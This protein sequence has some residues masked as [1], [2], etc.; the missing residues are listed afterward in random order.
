MQK[1]VEQLE[2]GYSF[3]HKIL[4]NE[5]IDIE[6]FG[7]SMTLFHY[8]TYFKS[9]KHFDRYKLIISC[10]FLSGKI[11]GIFIK[12]EILQ[13]LYKKYAQK[14]NEITEK[15]IVGFE[16]DL[17][18]FLG[19]EVDIETPYC[20]LDRMFRKTN[21][22]KLIFPFKKNTES[23]SLSPPNNDDTIDQN[24]NN[25]DIE[26]NKNSSTN[27]DINSCR[28]TKIIESNNKP[29]GMFVQHKKPEEYFQSLSVEEYSDKIRIIAFNILNDMYRRA[30]CI[31]F[32][33]RCIALV[34]F[35]ISF[36]L[37]VEGGNSDYHMDFKYF[38]DNY[39][40][41]GDYKDFLVCYN[42]VLS[43]FIK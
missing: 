42:E 27:N 41:E 35:M 14:N 11:K 40:P 33:P 22:N 17:L 26:N 7:I 4:I 23:T 8:Y 6:L 36:N 13:T 29:Q 1:Y 38:F 19:F 2:Q 21:F 28:I 20:Y 12:P 37:L 34:A 32:K 10:L 39:Y 16:L 30:Y 5:S 43:Y 31:V 9:F 15:E 18:V 25:Y 24:K 3:L